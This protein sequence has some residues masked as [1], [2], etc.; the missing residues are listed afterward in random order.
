MEEKSRGRSEA[1]GPEI[2]ALSKSME[3]AARDLGPALEQL[4]ALIDDMQNYEAPVRLP[5]GDILIRRKP[6]AAPPGPPEM[7]L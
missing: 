3:D 1:L 5:N 4:R 2:G 6:E 7:E